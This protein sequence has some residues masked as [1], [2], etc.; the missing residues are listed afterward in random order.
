MRER[1][2]LPSKGPQARKGERQRK[3]S[4]LNKYNTQVQSTREEGVLGAFRGEGFRGKCLEQWTSESGLR[5]RIFGRW[6][7]LGGW[8]GNVQKERAA[9]AKASFKA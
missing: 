2:P 4:Q 5:T 1:E 3:S 8:G 7:K 9:H 6:T